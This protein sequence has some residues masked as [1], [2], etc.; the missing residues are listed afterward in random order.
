MLQLTVNGLPHTLEAPC[1][2]AE[3]LPHL[4]FSGSFFAVA[5]NGDFV[6]KS[7]YGSVS[8]LGGEALEVL[9]PMQGG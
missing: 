2:L 9:S 8:L 6:P 4:G 7:R 3:A 5:I 1:P